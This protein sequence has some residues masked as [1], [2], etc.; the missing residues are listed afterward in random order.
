MQF[1]KSQID[2]I[3]KPALKLMADRIDY[4]T[5]EN[6]AYRVQI[7]SFGATPV[8]VP[9]PTP[10]PSP[11]PRIIIPTH[12]EGVGEDNCLKKFLKEI[13]NE[14]VKPTDKLTIKKKDIENMEG[15]VV[16]LTSEV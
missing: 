14:S 6:A 11:T 4:L 13:G 3:Y 9:E 16:I 15:E 5:E 10:A 8:T 7:A 2:A 1:T 12:F